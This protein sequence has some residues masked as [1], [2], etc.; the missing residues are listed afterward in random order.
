MNNANH[1]CLRFQFR[2][3]PAVLKSLSTGTQPSRQ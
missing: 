2:T 1:V 3:D